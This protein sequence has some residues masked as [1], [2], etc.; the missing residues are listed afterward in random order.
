MKLKKTLA[1][2]LAA[3]MALSMSVTAFAAGNVTTLT[4]KYEEFDVN[5]TV[6]TTG[7]VVINP[8]GMPYTLDDDVSS[9][10]GQLVSK[11]MYIA[12]RSSVA[13]SVGATVVATKETTSG[14]TFVDAVAAT[15]T[16][17]NVQLQLDV[18][19]DDTV[20]DGDEQDPSVVDP[21]YASLTGSPDGTVALANTT[22]DSKT[23]YTGTGEGLVVLRE[24][25][26]G[27][28]QTG[29]LAFF[30]LNGAVVKSPT[31]A[32]AATDTFTATVTFTFEPT[33]Y[34]FNGGTLT[35]ANISDGTLV[36]SAASDGQTVTLTLPSG[37][38]VKSG[39]TP[40]WVMT[41]DSGV[42]TTNQAK[43]TK[44][45]N[46]DGMSATF[47]STNTT[48]TTYGA[49]LYVEYE[50]TDGNTYRTDSIALSFTK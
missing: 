3:V 9:A 20:V 18:W 15:D 6:P 12:N 14:I 28:M 32:W 49:T 4:G 22:V 27:E 13:L 31:T 25:N 36:V 39:S 11:T 45:I 21:I 19:G 34:V 26:E 1:I 17:K 46:S 44:E 42:T 47:K 48:N 33:T 24:G 8:Y 2:A 7:T 23:V 10:T 41:F 38:T 43:C 16:A 30:K 40:N 50:G 5:V 37:V 29:G 35:N